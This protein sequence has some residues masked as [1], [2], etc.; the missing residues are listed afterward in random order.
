MKVKI[1]PNLPT[2]IWKSSQLPMPNLLQLR[3]SYSYIIFLAIN[4]FY[5]K[6]TKGVKMAGVT[7]SRF[8]VR[9]MEKLEEQPLTTWS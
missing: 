6:N 9:T 1:G 2:Q 3:I 7:Q 5:I 4:K 8:G